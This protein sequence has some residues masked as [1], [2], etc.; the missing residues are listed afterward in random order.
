MT[1]RPY[2]PEDSKVIC[3]WV[4]DEKQ[5]FQWSA[6]RIGKWPLKGNE[7]NENDRSLVRFGFVI[8]SPELRGKGNGRKMLELAIQYAKSQLHASRITLGVF[9]NNPKARACYESVGFKEYS[10]R[11][12]NILGS[13]WECVDMELF[14]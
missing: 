7:L 10:V 14:I 12:V 4:Q 6:D 1:L 8:V 3:N 5:L 2:T 11:S 13:D 9:A